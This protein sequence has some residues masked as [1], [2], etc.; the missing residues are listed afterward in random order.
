MIAGHC[1]IV[2]ELHHFQV[3]P[4]GG[5]ASLGIDEAIIGKNY[6]AIVKEIMIENETFIEVAKYIQIFL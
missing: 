3:S 5:R 1:G 2:L 6:D 4:S